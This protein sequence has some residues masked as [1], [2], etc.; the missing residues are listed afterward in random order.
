[1]DY[2]KIFADA[3]ARLREEGRYRVF[4]DL[5]RHAGEF[6]RATRY[7]GGGVEDVTVWVNLSRWGI[8]GC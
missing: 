8:G 7:A 1:M 3:I 6:P 4:A 5:E 2:D